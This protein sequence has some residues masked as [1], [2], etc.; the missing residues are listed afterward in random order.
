VSFQQNS[1]AYI[2][3]ADGNPLLIWGQ[4]FLVVI[5]LLLSGLLLASDRFFPTQAAQVRSQATDVLAPM[6]D[7]AGAPVRWA[8][9]RVAGFRAFTNQT[10]L[11]AQA[12]DL[13][14]Q[15]ER[16]AGELARRDGQLAELRAQ[17]N[18]PPEGQESFLTARVLLEGDSLF[19]SSLVLNVGSRDRVLLFDRAYSGQFV[20][21]DPVTGAPLPFVDPCTRVPPGPVPVHC[22]P[23]EVT[24]GLAVVTNQGIL[25]TLQTVGYNSSRVRLLTNIESRL[26]VLVGR[27]RVKGLVTGTNTNVLTLTASEA[28]PGTINVGDEVLTSTIDPDI[29]FLFRVGTV[30][31]TTPDLQVAPAA[32]GP[33]GVSSF[34]QVVLKEPLD[35]RDET[36]Q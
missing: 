17:L 30:I 35:V 24:P 28:L 25:G 3:G 14:G 22:Q 15:L 13:R 9:R 26:P 12:E 18:L 32:L 10:A 36:L 34:V 1:S 8:K 33:D 31:A 23:A 4:R 6:V 5:L 21:R 2:E 19:S 20:E 16:L 29:P 11:A 27:F 7:A